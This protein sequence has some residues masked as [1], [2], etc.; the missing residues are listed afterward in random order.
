[1]GVGDADGD[2]VDSV[3]L[4]VVLMVVGDSVG[5][6]VVGDAVD[7]EGLVVVGGNSVG[8]GV[9]SEVPVAPVSVICPGL[10]G[11]KTDVGAKVPKKEPIGAEVP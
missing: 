3:G 8:L 2:T 5:L 10:M 6:A 7:S 4:V 11:P 9:D 1:M